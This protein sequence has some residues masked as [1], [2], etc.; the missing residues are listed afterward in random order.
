MSEGKLKGVSERLFLTS[1]SVLDVIFKGLFSEEG[2]FSN[3][4]LVGL[5]AGVDV[6]VSALVFG[7]GSLLWSVK[8][9]SKLSIVTIL[10][11]GLFVG[12]F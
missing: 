9:E 4:L 10:A 11:K 6:A 2:W 12:G 7:V 3:S 5:S 8:S 1:I